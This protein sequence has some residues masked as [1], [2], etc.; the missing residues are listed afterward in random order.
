MQYTDSATNYI[1]HFIKLP[2]INTGIEFMCLVCL[3]LRLNHPLS[4]TYRFE[5][6]RENDLRYLETSICSHLFLPHIFL[7]G[8]L[9]D[10]IISFPSRK[11]AYIVLI[12]L[13]PTFI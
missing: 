12:P 13:N 3:E 10:V 8:S 2:I 4:V 11:H 5:T 6:M 9:S 7:T 1:R